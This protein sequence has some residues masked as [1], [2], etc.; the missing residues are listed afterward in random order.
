M[1]VRENAKRL[2]LAHCHQAVV[3]TQLAIDVRKVLVD[4]AGR[5][6]QTSSDCSRLHALVQ[7]RENLHLAVCQARGLRHGS[8][9]G[10]VG[11]DL[12]LLRST[13]G[14]GV[15]IDRTHHALTLGEDLGF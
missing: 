11:L 6:S 13:Q 10:R 4:C 2:R 1:R 15:P 7:P 3:R 8:S 12:P 14:E 5:Y 9:I